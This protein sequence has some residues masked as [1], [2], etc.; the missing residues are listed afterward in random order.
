MEGGTEGG[1]EVGIPLIS[2]ISTYSAESLDCRVAFREAGVML[3][4]FAVEAAWLSVSAAMGVVESEDT[5]KGGVLCM[6]RWKVLDG[7]CMR[8]WIAAGENRRRGDVRG[9][10]RASIEWG[11]E[12]QERNWCGGVCVG[13]VQPGLV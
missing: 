8:D 3:E 4:V 12:T 13:E 7:I 1:G 10:R 2:T 9:R 5:R 6:V 11:G